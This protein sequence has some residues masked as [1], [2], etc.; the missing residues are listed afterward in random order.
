VRA[1]PV[2]YR[3]GPDRLCAGHQ[4]DRDAE[5]GASPGLLDTTELMDADRKRRV[6]NATDLAARLEARD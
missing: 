4:R 3:G 6:V 5:A 2:R 1:C